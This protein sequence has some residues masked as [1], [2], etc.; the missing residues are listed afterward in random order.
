MCSNEH[1]AFANSRRQWQSRKPFRKNAHKTYN[2]ENNS[3]TE[4][5]YKCYGCGKKGH[6][7]SDCPTKKSANCTQRNGNEANCTKN[8]MKENEISFLANTIVS[9]SAYK[10]TDK[11]GKI[12]TTISSSLAGE[13]IRAQKSGTL[14]AQTENGLPIKIENVIECED[15]PY[16]LFIC[17]ESRRGLQV[18]FENG[19]VK[20]MSNAKPDFGARYHVSDVRMEDE[21]MHQLILKPSVTQKVF[22]S[23]TPFQEI[24]NR[25]GFAKDSIELY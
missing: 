6:K 21:N 5:P 3:M 13:V 4:F 2:S 16:N 9:E 18:L 7:K 11:M 19:T 10:R 22:R 12:S 20:I 23:N 14:H 1:V 15:V 24:L 8:T 25:M 17:S